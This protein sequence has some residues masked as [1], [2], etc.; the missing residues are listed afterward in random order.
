MLPLRRGHFLS[1]YRRETKKFSLEERG[2]PKFFSSSPR[3]RRL[4]LLKAKDANGNALENSN[5]SVSQS[6]NSRRIRS[7]ST[8]FFFRGARVACVLVTV[9][10]L[11]LNVVFSLFFHASCVAGD[12]LKEKRGKNFE[13]SM[14]KTKRKRARARKRERVNE[15]EREF[16]TQKPTVLLLLILLKCAEEDFRRSFFYFTRK[17][18]TSQSDVPVKPPNASKYSPD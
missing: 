18:E 1:F 4:S 3:G 12:E 16:V 17:Q 9:F 11:T 8:R 10:F 13:Y 2:Q 6:G 14:R 7:F 15:R 5:L